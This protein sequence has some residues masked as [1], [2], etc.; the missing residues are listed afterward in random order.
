MTIQAAAK[1]TSRAPICA[2]LLTAVVAC[3]AE[4]RLLWYS[5]KHKD[6]DISNGTKPEEVGSCIRLCACAVE[7]HT[8]Q[9]ETHIVC[10]LIP[11]QMDILLYGGEGMASLRPEFVPQDKWFIAAEFQPNTTVSVRNE[12]HNYRCHMC[13]KLAIPS[14]AGLMQRFEESPQ[15]MAACVHTG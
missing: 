15:I 2:S 5:S 13:I 11:L 10:A 4:D 7:L 8:M 6:W 9:S 1:V 12:L 14:D 3:I